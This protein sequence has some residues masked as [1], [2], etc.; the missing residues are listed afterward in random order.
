MP[1]KLGFKRYHKKVKSISGSVIFLLIRHFVPRYAL[2]SCYRV[3]SKTGPRSSRL[4]PLTAVP[5]IPAC[6]CQE[7][8][9][10]NR[11]L[12]L[13]CH[14]TNASFKQWVGI[15]LMLKIDRAR[16]NYLTPEI[17]EETHLRVWAGVRRQLIPRKCSL[18]L[19]GIFYDTLTFWQS[20]SSSMICIGRHVGGHTLALQHDSQNYFLLIS[21]LTFDSYIQMCCKRYHIIFSTFSLQ[22]KCKICVQK[23]VISHFGHVT[24]YELTHFKKMVQVWKTKSILFCLRYDPLSIFWRQSHITFIFIKTMSHDL[25]VQL[26]NRKIFQKIKP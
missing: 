6:A 13:R 24:S 19:Q 10:E 1:F 12:A 8:F 3:I 5:D 15:S 4:T 26:A 14:V 17:W 23:E 21:C 22:F 18:C 7:T 20:W 9:R 11:P 25:L 16:K 2:S